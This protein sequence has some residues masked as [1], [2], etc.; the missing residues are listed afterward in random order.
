M[1]KFVLVSALV[2]AGTAYAT[3]SDLM[4]YMPT[5]NA[6]PHL[7]MLNPA[8]HLPKAAEVAYSD[9]YRLT[10]TK[11][12]RDGANELREIKNEIENDAR[13]IGF[14]N[15]VGGG[16][17]LGVIAGY[18]RMRVNTKDDTS[19]LYND[20]YAD[21]SSVKKSVSVLFNMEITQGMRFGVSYRHVIVKNH[22]IGSTS[23]ARSNNV[24]MKGSLSGL[25]VGGYLGSGQLA[26]G[27]FYRLPARGK[28]DVLG[29]D[30]ISSEEG[31]I[32]AGVQYDLSK[33]FR[34]GLSLLKWMYERDELAGTTTNMR[35]QTIRMN[36]LSTEANLRTTESIFVGA[37]YSLTSTVTGRFALG[38]EQM[39]F[40][41]DATTISSD[42][43]K[44][45]FYTPRARGGL[46]LGNA[47]F[48][49]Y[50]GADYVQRKN[51]RTENNV[52][53][54]HKAT[55]YTAVGALSINF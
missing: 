52:A 14:M 18:D 10:V 43:S 15:R 53:I 3:P 55:E 11:T 49:L 34:L 25:T 46:Q 26:F 9:A 23:A 31:L 38:Y 1:K 32:G 4:L 42:E 48:S 24:E 41:D 39:L 22:I 6:G 45:N 13:S 47:N 2:F 51:S 21:E 20:E 40:I 19:F 33:E 17:G 5:D 50:L 8:V 37:D 16:V 27:L 35:E 44:R 29:E 30:K 7:F 12:R 36:G 54:S 28:V